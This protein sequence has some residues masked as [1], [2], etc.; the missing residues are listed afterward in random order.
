MLEVI[1]TTY[2]SDGRSVDLS[3]LIDTMVNSPDNPPTDFDTFEYVNNQF[4]QF[5]GTRAIVAAKNFYARFGTDRW[6][7]I[8]YTPVGLIGDSDKGGLKATPFCQY[9]ERNNHWSNYTLSNSL[10]DNEPPA[11]LTLY[12][13]AVYG[14]Y[15]TPYSPKRVLNHRI[16]SQSGKVYTSTNIGVARL[17]LPETFPAVSERSRLPENAR[18]FG[19]LLM[20]VINHERA[21]STT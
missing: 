19:R 21:M 12:T 5:T 15:V 11:Q 6:R 17:Q 4:E 1:T 16:Q 13:P 7:T 9:D 10:N 20:D 2:K 14:I 18:R 3:R 8:A